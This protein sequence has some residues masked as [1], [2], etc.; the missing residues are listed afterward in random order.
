MFVPAY[1]LGAR[2]DPPDDVGDLR[3]L[4]ETVGC[5]QT[6]EKYYLYGSA[7]SP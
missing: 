4:Y 2:P 7:L 6:S 3:L 5:S 1:R